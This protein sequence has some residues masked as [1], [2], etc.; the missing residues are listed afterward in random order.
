MCYKFLCIVVKFVLTVWAY[1]TKLIF[2]EASKM[3]TKV[4]NGPIC[5]YSHVSIKI[6]PLL[7]HLR[8]Q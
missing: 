4:I 3:Q 2:L 7:F 5:N 8:A 1:R 6:E